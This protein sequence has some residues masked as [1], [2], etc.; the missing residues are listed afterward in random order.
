MSEVSNNSQGE[1]DANPS[2]QPNADKPKKADYKVGYGKPPKATQFKKGQSGNPKGAKKKKEIDDARIVIEEVLAEPIELR[3]GGRK[4][5]VSKLEAM[6]RAQLISALKGN[7]KAVK[8]FY[9][10]AQ[11]AHLF[12]QAE[13][14]SFMVFD[15]PGGN[16]ED[17]M[18]LRA[19]HA[20][21]DARDQSADPPT[22]SAAGKSGAT[23][24]D[25]G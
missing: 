24:Q 25:R 12:S 5:R 22:D 13:L 18:I 23:H 14:K 1:S 19:F 15:P 8:A 4:L 9:R 6:L 7:H 2:D 20:E 11:K 3:D 16:P 21:E 17:Q 10:L